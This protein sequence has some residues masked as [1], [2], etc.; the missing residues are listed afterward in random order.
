MGSSLFPNELLE[1][2]EP[3]PRVEFVGFLSKFISLSSKEFSVEFF[4][5][6][7]DRFISLFPEFHEFNNFFIVFFHFF[8]FLLRVDSS[9][10]HGVIFQK[11]LSEFNDFGE[12]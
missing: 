12:F 7:E 2:H 10:F 8:E 5:L 9:G 3:V 6:V 1:A 11:F 4:I